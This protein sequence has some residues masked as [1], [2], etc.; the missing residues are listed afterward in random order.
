[1]NIRLHE[2]SENRLIRKRYGK[3]LILFVLLIGFLLNSP[4]CLA[5]GKAEDEKAEL[6]IETLSNVE[7]DGSFFVRLSVRKIKTENGIV[8]AVFHV[9]FDPSA[10]ELV[11]WENAT[12]SGWVFDQT[13]A[14]DWTTVVQTDTDAYLMFTQLNPDCNAGVTKDGELQTTLRFRAKQK[15][16]ASCELHITDICF[17]TD[18]L[19]DT[20]RLP[21]RTYTV[22]IPDFFQSTENEGKALKITIAVLSALAVLGASVCTFMIARKR[23]L[24]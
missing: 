19:T 13:T 8:C 18:T 7:E 9:H 12:P 3:G 11:S 2:R 1:M 17:A 22:N 23:K 10:V 4:H 21:N 6:Q 24:A 5:E 14:E 16:L 20:L 15:D